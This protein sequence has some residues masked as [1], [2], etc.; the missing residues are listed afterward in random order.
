MSSPLAKAT[1]SWTLYDNFNSEFLDIEKWGEHQN[2]TGGVVALDEVREIEGQRLYISI[3]AHG[4]T[5]DGMHRGDKHITFLNPNTIRGVKASIKVNELEAMQCPDQ[6]VTSTQARARFYGSFFNT[7]GAC[8]PPNCDQ[9][10][11]VATQIFIQRFS[12]SQDNS[13]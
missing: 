12:D 8:V 9:A 1:D 13:L 6:G 2:K 11:D 7:V 3:R 4:P 5:Q 10:H